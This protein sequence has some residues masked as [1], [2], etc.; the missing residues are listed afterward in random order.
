MVTGIQ[1]DQMNT[2]EKEK[3]VGKSLRNGMKL[4]HFCP[5]CSY[6]VMQEFISTSYI[7]KEET[8]REAYRTIISARKSLIA[9]HM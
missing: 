7:F 4:K 8:I 5:V 9:S 3:E 2:E 6:L 1:K